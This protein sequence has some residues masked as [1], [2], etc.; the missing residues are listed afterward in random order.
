MI[1]R[2]RHLLR[3]FALFAVAASASAQTAP[4]PVTAIPAATD[5][6]A[7]A[8]PA[9]T[10]PAAAPDDQLKQDHYTDS[11]AAVVNGNI[12]TLN[13]LHS[14][15]EPLVP[16]IAQEVDAKYGDDPAKAQEIFGQQINER[17]MELL[18][19]MVDRRLIIQEFNDK[20]YKVP[21]SYLERQFE[22]KMTT[23]F[24][25]DRTAFL[26]YLAAHNLTEQEYRKQIEEDDIL[27]YMVDQI[28]SSDT[29]LSPDR[30]KKYYETH[31]EDF[32]VQASV[33]VRQ[34]AISAVAD[35]P[36]AEQAAKIVQEARQPG[37]N[38]AE[39]AQKYSSDP[40]ARA[41]TLPDQT[42]TS[43]S[44]LP[45]RSA[46]SHLQPQTR[47]CQRP[48]DNPRRAVRR[49]RHLHLQVRRANPRRLLET[50]RRPHGHR[51][52]PRQAGHQPGL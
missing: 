36:V 41:G 51:R 35:S 28:H 24:N 12:I 44:K 8:A 20:G 34:I 3:S 6:P 32:H 33:K 49:N 18:K 23:D 26:K 11:V 30:I 9:T 31:K 43:D 16:E 39:L 7:A 4:T 5:A 48:G 10:T 22:D 1:P 46:A 27:G 42:F 14:A 15:L 2:F 25:D 45:P 40:L 21:D 47:R 50:R 13:E 17:G 37:A 29:G 19:S 38:F 52:H